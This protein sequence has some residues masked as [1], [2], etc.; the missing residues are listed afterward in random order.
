MTAQHSTTYYI[1][2]GSEFEGRLYQN[3]R[4]FL[5][6]GVAWG[7]CRK[8]N[9]ALTM[10]PVDAGKIL[11]KSY[12]THWV[13]P[14]TIYIRS[15]AMMARLDF[16]NQRRYVT[17]SGLLRA[18][19]K[20]QLDAAYKEIVTAFGDNL[21]TSPMF[22]VEWFIRTGRKDV[23][24]R[25]LDQMA[26]DVLHNACYPGIGDVQAF[27]DAYLEAAEPILILQGEP[28][29]GKTRLVRFLMGELARD[30][31]DMEHKPEIMYA[32]DETLFE[33]DELFVRFL[34]DNYAMMV[35][36]DADHLMKPRSDGNKGLHFFLKAA[37]GIIRATNKKIIFTT[38]LPNIRDIDDALARPGR[39]FQRVQ[40]G[41]LS[42]AQAVAAAKA[43]YGE[44]ASLVPNARGMSLAEIYAWGRR[45][46]L[47]AK[48]A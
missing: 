37:D 38:N 39:C 13:N 31:E 9:L 46:K 15:Q 23:T 7:G 22:E 19:T 25:S 18:H 44:G 40:L 17:M 45:N 4:E 33:S 10:E 34:T 16:T 47:E 5:A 21:I 2:L 14:N 43:I 6:G 11:S 3:D 32:N 29:T 8:I 48:A 28:G 42:P 20:E 30:C 27:A 24:S 35:V 1:E 26:D 41:S 36:E 12:A